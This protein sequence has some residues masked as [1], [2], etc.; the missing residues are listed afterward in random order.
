ML[1]GSQTPPAISVSFRAAPGWSKRYSV[2]LINLIQPLAELWFSAALTTQP[3]TRSQLSW[4]PPAA[5]TLLR[6]EGIVCL[7]W[8]R[9]GAGATGW[10]SRGSFRA[11]C[12][13][14]DTTAGGLLTLG[15][16]WKVWPGLRC[17]AGFYKLA[18]VCFPNL[19]NAAKN[20]QGRGDVVCAGDSGVGMLEGLRGLPS[21]EPEGMGSLRQGC[22]ER[23]RALLAQV[24]LLRVLSP[25]L[26]G[27]NWN[28][29]LAPEPCISPCS[30][31]LVPHR[32]WGMQQRAGSPKAAQMLSAGR[33]LLGRIIGKEAFARG[34]C[35]EV[36]AAVFILEGFL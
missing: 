8:P 21:T 3:Q 18:V 1:P 15:K 14:A 29:V 16:G 17:L 31:K 11:E 33:W 28:L 35:A 26:R 4:Q 36:L 7:R 5:P 32:G 20:G 24:P 23:G 25:L 6:L 22:N 13:Q 9:R 2:P 12:L 30:V 10:R 19:T 34:L 27:G